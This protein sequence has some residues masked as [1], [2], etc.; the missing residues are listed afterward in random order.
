MFFIMYHANT[1]E[2]SMFVNLKTKDFQYSHGILYS[3][4]KI[5][6]STHS[7]IP[8]SLFIEWECTSQ[9]IY[10]DVSPPPGLKS[11]TF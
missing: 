6:K 9:D 7:W 10:Y 5:C 3:I 11:D 1:Q 2:K 4:I 8:C